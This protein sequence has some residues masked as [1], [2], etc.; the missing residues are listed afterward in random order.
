LIGYCNTL[1]TPGIAPS[2]AAKSAAYWEVQKDDKHAIHDGRHAP[3]GIST[4]APPIEI[5]HPI[6]NDFIRFIDDP[7]VQPTP[8]DLDNVRTLMSLASGIYLSEEYLMKIKAQLRQVLVKILFNA[9][10]D[11]DETEADVIL[12]TM[13]NS[14][15]FMT[16]ALEWRRELGEG[17][18]D[19]STQAGLS[20]KRAWLESN[21]GYNCCIH[22]KFISDY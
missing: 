17:G 9:K 13:I 22:I 5:F 11:D 21:V 10:A 19:S 18:Y 20:M 8:E 6:F 16:L 4:I 2:S 3:A 14:A 12:K 7:N 15:Q 1:Q